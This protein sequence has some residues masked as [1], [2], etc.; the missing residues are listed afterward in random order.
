MYVSGDCTPHC[1]PV[2]VQHAESGPE[3]WRCPAHMQAPGG[4]P[5]ASTVALDAVQR[6]LGASNAAMVSIASNLGKMRMSL[7]GITQILIVSDSLEAFADY[8]SR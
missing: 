2:P 8:F 7:V 1:P 3:P 6:M 4:H 5:Q